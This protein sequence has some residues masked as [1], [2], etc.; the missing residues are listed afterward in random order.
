M[1]SMTAELIGTAILVLLGNGVVANV[2]LT[3]TKGRDAGWIVITIGWGLAVFAG[4]AL[5]EQFSGAHL[6]PAVSIGLAIAGK[7]AWS[8]A[9][10]FIAAQMAGGFVGALLVYAVY[11]QH[12]DLTDDPDTKLATFCTAPAVRSTPFNLI[13]E[14]IGTFVLVFAVLLFV[15]ANVTDASGNETGMVGL[16]AVGALPVALIVVSIGMSLGGTTG[17]AINPA[18]DLSPRL[19]HAILPIRGK[20]DSDWGYAWIPVVGPVIGAALAAVVY[21]TFAAPSAPIVH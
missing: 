20:R 19:A 21:L 4:V 9:G 18:R 1:N 7:F 14:V 6:N 15:G 16:G 11:K 10:G 2:V 5:T 8:D 12:Y 13:S 3:Q 17:Y